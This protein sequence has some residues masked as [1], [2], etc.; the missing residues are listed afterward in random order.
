MLP[1]LTWRHK[2]GIILSFLKSCQILA[3]LDFST[4]DFCKPKHLRHVGDSCVLNTPLGCPVHCCP[5]DCG[6]VRESTA[7]RRVRNLW[8]EGSLKVPTSARKRRGVLTFLQTSLNGADTVLVT[9]CLT[10]TFKTNLMN[11]GK[12][13]VT[14]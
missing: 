1:V 10:T 3:S 13:T 14:D 8:Y 7:G 6:V 5:I 9:L 4:W 12:F 11:I 2:G